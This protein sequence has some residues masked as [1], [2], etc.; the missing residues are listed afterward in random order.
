[1]QNFTAVT[2]FDIAKHHFSKDMVESFVVNWPDDVKL[3]IF[4][5]NS[6]LIKLENLNKK[7][8]I[9]DYHKYIPEYKAFCKKFH[10]KK[11]FTDDFRYNVFRFAYKVYAIKKSFSYTNSKNLIWLDADIKTHKKI[12]SNFLETLISDDHYLSYLGRSHIKTN[13]LNYS[14]CGFLIFNTKHPHHNLFWKEM[15]SMYN[16]G[17]LF[18][19]SEWHDSFIFDHVRKKLEKENMLKNINITDF[20]IVK[21]ESKYDDHV[22][23]L[24]VLGKFMD[25]KKGIRKDIKWSPEL[26]KRIKKDIKM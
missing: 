2:T 15:M 3:L 26:L 12:P 19:L 24:S 20:G 16:D 10:H 17:L 13:H 21:I 18:E 8:Q 14:E 4:M 22:F 25:H 7:I 5:E 6:H 9:F 1:M 23:V 11:K